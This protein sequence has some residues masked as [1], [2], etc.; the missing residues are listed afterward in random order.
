MQARASVSNCGSKYKLEQVFLSV[1]I[2]DILRGVMQNVSYI[3]G[4]NT[5]A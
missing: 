3:V 2:G 4:E 1:E 5:V